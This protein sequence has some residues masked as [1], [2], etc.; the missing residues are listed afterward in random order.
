MCVQKIWFCMLIV[1]SLKIYSHF[2]FF[3][4]LTLVIHSL[5]SNTTT[6][7]TFIVLC[8]TSLWYIH[9]MNSNDIHQAE[10]FKLHVYCVGLPFNFKSF[11]RCDM[12]CLHRCP[13]RR[14]QYVS[15]S[16]SFFSTCRYIL[17]FRNPDLGDFKDKSAHWTLFQV[18][19]HFFQC[20]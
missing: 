16:S 19:H 3:A 14:F 2:F 13:S 5:L 17:D 1:I 9:L 8:E 20:G 10:T 11:D 4:P 7:S 15:L 12:D 6:R 18:S